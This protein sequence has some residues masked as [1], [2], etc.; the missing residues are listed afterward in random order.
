MKVI[1]DLDSYLCPIIIYDDMKYNQR[2]M[3]NWR[4]RNDFKTR[5]VNLFLAAKI[6]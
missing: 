4:W 1:S 6:Y 5:V 3:T 2:R